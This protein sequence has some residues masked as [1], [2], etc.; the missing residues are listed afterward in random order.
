VRNAVVAW[1]LWQRDG[2]AYAVEVHSHVKQQ[3][4]GLW[5]EKLAN[6]HIFFIHGGESQ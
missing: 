2:R 4:A 6:S 1:R 5:R 3:V